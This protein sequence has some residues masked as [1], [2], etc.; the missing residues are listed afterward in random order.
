M[1]TYNM[2]GTIWNLVNTG[3]LPVHVG[4][5]IG[6]TLQ[7]DRSLAPMPG[8]PNPYSATIG[9]GMPVSPLLNFVDLT[10]HTPL[11]SPSNN[12]SP[13][14][15]GY[16]NYGLTL[17]PGSPNTRIE[18]I[19]SATWLRSS[20]GRYSF[21]NLDLEN[22]KA[23]LPAND[24]AHLQLSGVPFGIRSLQYGY[25]QSTSSAPELEF[26]VK[27]DP[28]SGSVS[29]TPEPSSLVLLTVGAIGLIASRTCSRR[30]SVAL[31]RRSLIQRDR[32][33]CRAT[34]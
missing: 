3:N 26:L 28:L 29:S 16:P 22:N 34:T 5:R 13:S 4:D 30:R 15:F 21:A 23:A 2:T 12:P 14:P 27:A 8:T 10:T 33:R 18:F 17:N 19:A 9:Y 24:L 32:L 25:E 1:V 31:L 6:W 7:Y 11:N 20:D